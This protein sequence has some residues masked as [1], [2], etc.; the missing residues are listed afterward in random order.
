MAIE[1]DSGPNSALA[2]TRASQDK[3]KTMTREGEETKTKTGYN[4]NEPLE[5][6]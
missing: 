3:P 5:V 1:P 2:T 4:R 6:E